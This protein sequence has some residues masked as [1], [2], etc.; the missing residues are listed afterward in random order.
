[1][2]TMLAAI[3][4]FHLVV[5]AIHGAAHTGARVFL[6]FAGNLFVYIVIL[7]GPLAG[8][9][10][11]VWRPQAGATLVAVTLAGS[12]A[13][14][15]VN[16]FIIPGADH[17]AHVAREWRSLFATTAVLLAVIEAAG[18]AIGFRL[19]RRRAGRAS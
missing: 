9:A 5:S 19:A 2:R 16:H 15:L 3:V 14:G 11:S 8:L 6:P 7:A 10:L 4:I 17:V 1:M 12:F 13:F 18:A